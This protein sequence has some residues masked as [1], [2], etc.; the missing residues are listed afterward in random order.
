M[1]LRRGCAEHSRELKNLLDGRVRKLG[2]RLDTLLTAG[3]TEGI[4]ARKREGD[5]YA[6]GGTS[7]N[8]FSGG[9]AHR[10]IVVDSDA[11]CNL[12]GSRVCASPTL[13]KKL[14][15]R[16]SQPPEAAFQI[17]TSLEPSPL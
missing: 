1:C 12:T 17:V 5:Q 8:R 14:S 6:D 11:S 13:G 4:Q 2:P 16:E 7:G 15:Q 10:C 9:S 3:N